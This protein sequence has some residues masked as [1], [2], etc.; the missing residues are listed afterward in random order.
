MLAGLDGSVSKL[1]FAAFRI[2]PYYPGFCSSILVMD[3]SRFDNQTLDEMA[4]E[5]NEELD[6]ED[7]EPG[8]SD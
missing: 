3:L 5:D 6:N 1:H 4:A 7:S 8:D 2:V